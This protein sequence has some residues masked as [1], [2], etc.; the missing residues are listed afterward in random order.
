MTQKINGSAYPGVWVEKQVTFAK[1]VFSKDISALLTADLFVLGTTTAAGA[2]TVADSSFAVVESALVQSLKTLET[3]STVLGISKYKQITPTVVVT[4]T[5]GSSVGT[6]ITVTSTTSL[7]AGQTVAVT[8]GTGS[9]VP[10]TKVLSVTDSTHFVVSIAPTVAL[11][12]ATVTGSTFAGG[13]VDVMLGYAEGWFSDIAGV[14]ASTQTIINAEATVFVAGSSPTNVLGAL[15]SVGAAAVTFTTEFVAFDGSMPV[16]TFAN[17]DLDL[18]A[19]G[20]TPGSAAAP[21]GAS[22]YYPN[23]LIT[24]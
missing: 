23:L 4:M 13:Q 12:G 9:F 16:A 22:G 24:A 17:G 2:N 5:S 6:T 19:D 21:M 14:I 3:K 8:A 7:V 11:S 1:L 18:V 15:V 10:G 20:A